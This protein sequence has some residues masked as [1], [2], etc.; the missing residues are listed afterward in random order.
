MMGDMETKTEEKSLPVIDETN[1]LPTEKPHTSF[2]ELTMHEEC[3]WKHMLTYI[4]KIG[5]DKGSIHTVYGHLIHS[6]IEQYLMTGVEPVATPEAVEEQRQKF[7]EDLAETGIEYKPE[8]VAQF[9]ASGLVALRAFPE[10]FKSEFP[11][12]EVVGVEIPL[13]EPVPPLENRFFKGYVDCVLKIPKKPRKN[14]KKPVEGHY[15]MVI[16]WKTTSWG[17]TVDKKRDFNKQKQLGYYKHYISQKYN[18]P[19]ADV[20]CAF[21]LIKRLVKEDR[22]PFEIVPVS[23]GEGSITKAMDGLKKHLNIL[24]KSLFLKN[25]SACKYCEYKSTVHCT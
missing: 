10:W 22:G 3:S 12:A 15:F 19:Y 8:E 18:V 21:V 4:K 14:S 25:R 9:F 11:D 5:N 24:N 2:S 17:W 7:V 1:L 16:D 20:K 23:L 13:Y 6:N